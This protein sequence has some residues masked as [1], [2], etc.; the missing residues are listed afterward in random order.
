MLTT[1][2]GLQ[3]M[4]TVRT[5]I[6]DASFLFLLFFTFPLIVCSY[7]VNNIL[8]SKLWVGSIE[9]T[10]LILY[11]PGSLTS[12]LCFLH[13]IF[14][15]SFSDWFHFIYTFVSLLF[16]TKFWLI[17]TTSGVLSPLVNKGLSVV[18]RP[19]VSQEPWRCEDDF[20]FNLEIHLPHEIGRHCRYSFS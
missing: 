11:F 18:P 6:T 2:S 3:R 13:N 5:F 7:V 19:Q 8:I 16:A 12:K 17:P 10:T 4:W 14:H 9:G 20:D 1:N 15:K